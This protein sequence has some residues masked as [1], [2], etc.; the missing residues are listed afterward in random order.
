MSQKVIEK[1]SHSHLVGL[2]SSQPASYKF[3]PTRNWRLIKIVVVSDDSNS[4]IHVVD[5]LFIPCPHLAHFYIKQVIHVSIFTSFLNHWDVWILF[6]NSG[7]IVSFMGS[8]RLFSVLLIFFPNLCYFPI[9]LW[10]HFMLLILDRIKWFVIW[11]DSTSDLVPLVIVAINLASLAVLVPDLHVYIHWWQSFHSETW[12]WSVLLLIPLWWNVSQSRCFFIATLHSQVL[13]NTLVKLWV[14]HVIALNWSIW[15]ESGI[16][17]IVFRVTVV[18]LIFPIWRF[19]YFLWWC[20]N[21]FITASLDSFWR[22]VWRS[23]FKNFTSLHN[24]RSIFPAIKLKL[25]QLSNKTVVWM[26]LNKVKNLQ[27]FFW[28][29]FLYKHCRMTCYDTWW[30]KP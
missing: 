18:S 12:V 7:F 27:F 28:T 9:N 17:L 8:F 11:T 6:L 23:H 24:N 10:V 29:L 2:K 13:D 16:V 22:R 25:P 19:S 4:S 20:I 15:M 26:N 1:T 30:N 3:R 21:S 14:F 5:W